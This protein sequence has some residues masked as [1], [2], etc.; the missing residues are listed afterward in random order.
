[1]PVLLLDRIKKKGLKHKINP[2]HPEKKV[3]KLIQS[4]T[5]EQRD[6]FRTLLVRD[7]ST[8]ASRYYCLACCVGSPFESTLLRREHTTAKYEH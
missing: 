3:E 6:S 1:M 5:A 8:T 7:C 2:L 4:L